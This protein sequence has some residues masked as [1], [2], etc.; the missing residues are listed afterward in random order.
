[1]RWNFVSSILFYRAIQRIHFNNREL[2]FSF[3]FFCSIF[4]SE[5]VPENFQVGGELFCSGH[6]ERSK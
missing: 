1:M 3:F 4:I 2:W 6:L 5:K